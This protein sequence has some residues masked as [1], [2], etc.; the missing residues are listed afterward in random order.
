MFI[1]VV[2]DMVHSYLLYWQFHSVNLHTHKHTTQ[3]KLGEVVYVN[4]PEVGAEFEK[5]DELGSLESVK[6]VSEVYSPLSGKITEVNTELDTQPNL[7]NEHPFG[8]GNYQCTL[9]YYYSRHNN[10]PHSLLI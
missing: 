2:V 4:L 9:N 7:I 1:R 10:P 5:G 6:A 8:E 3:D